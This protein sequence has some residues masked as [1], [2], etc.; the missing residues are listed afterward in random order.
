MKSTA[1]KITESNP[2]TMS[3]EET[4]SI[5]QDAKPMTRIKGAGPTTVA[6]QTIIEVRRTGHSQ[7]GYSVYTV[8]TAA[9]YTYETK[10]DSSILFSIENYRP[11]FSYGPGKIS[12]SSEYRRLFCTVDLQLDGWGKIVRV[13]GPDAMAVRDQY[14]G[15]KTG[16]R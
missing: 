8:T 7:N 1:T 9:G 5:I 4:A 11:T 2:R 10:R 12:A 15:R 16:G 13:D 3:H 14:E 6:D